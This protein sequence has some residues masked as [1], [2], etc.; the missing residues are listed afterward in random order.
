[1]AATPEV[2]QLAEAVA[3]SLDANPQTRRSAEQT[4]DE[5]QAS[6]TFAVSMLQL[7]ALDSFP[8][9]IRQAA[10]VYLKN[11]ST[12]FY[13]QADWEARSGEPQT[14]LKAGIVGVVLRSPVSV[15]RQLSA[16]LAV[17]AEHEYPT[18]WPALVSELAA[19]LEA[20]ARAAAGAAADPAAA[21]EWG[22]LQ[23]ALES[24]A[25]I[26]ERYPD[27][28]RSDELFTEINVSLQHTAPRLR[29]LLPVM[30]R[31]VTQ[32][33]AARD[34]TAVE[35]IVGNAALMARVF[36]LL[37]WQDL[38]AYIEDNM[39]ALMQPLKQLLEFEDA[40]IDAAADDE[41]SCIDAMHAA[42]IDALNLYAGKYDEEFRPYLQFFVKDVWELLVKRSNVP[43]Y[44]KVV[45]TGIKFLTTV[46]RSPDHTLF[47]DPSAL[48]QVC[49]SI[50]VPNIQL[51][52]ED[53]ELFEDNAVEYIR[54][55]MEGSDSGTRRR[56]AVELVKGLCQNYDKEVTEIFS[57]HVSSML[58]PGSAWEKRDAALYIV[59]ALGWKS[60]TAAHGATETSQ[61]INVVD[62]FQNQV[63]PELTA[64]ASSPTELKAPIFTADLIK[65]AISF[66]VQIPKAS[67][68][69]LIEHCVR[70]LSAKEPVVKT[71]AAACIERLLTVKEPNV[72]T[73]R[74][75]KEDLAPMLSV[76]L[77]HIMDTLQKSTRADE[78]LMR[79]VLRLCSV[80]KEGMKDYAPQLVTS[81]VQV[82]EVVLKNPENPLFNHYLFEAIAALIRFNVTSANVAA[83]E[84]QLNPPLQTILREDVTEFA[85]YVFQVLSQLMSAHAGPLPPTYA[86]LIEPILT[87]NMWEKRGYV[88]SMVQ[89]IEAYC[90]KNSEGVIASGKM[91]GIL[92][93]F[94]KLLAS[95]PLDHLGL[96]LLCTIIETYD[97][98]A[99]AQYIN[100]IV[101]VLMTR[102]MQARTTKYVQNLL[103]T[104]SVFVIRYGVTAL[105]TSLDGQQQG[106]LDTL[107]RQV[108]LPCV[109][110]ILRPGERRVCAVALADIACATDLC[111][112]APYHALW[113][114]LVTAAVKLMEGVTEDAK[115]DEDTGKEEEE[116]A[117]LGGGESYS[118]A[119]SQLQW[120]IS[121]R[122]RAADVAPGVDPK[123]RLAGGIVQLSMRHPGRFGGI[124]ETGVDPAV[125]GAIQSYITATG[126]TVH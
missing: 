14:Q 17:M 93:V 56:G 99:I 112:E 104:L 82:L 111:A 62:F 100:S 95:K 84:A 109:S 115:E 64:S 40:S 123:Q 120:G 61:L 122:R 83:F 49:N 48:A 59:T 110:T 86:Q 94:Q 63:L 44:D 37:S 125:K 32:G 34:P 65:Y 55:D 12:R 102:L 31:V 27:R 114:Q 22:A 78:Y 26:F 60:G 21:I 105:K 80:A 88:P 25:A 91:V 118:A 41:P 108:W 46:A 97:A 47:K 92:G 19:Q 75:S 53:K 67:Y 45:T 72:R 18:R 117:H 4:L 79:L 58:A 71:Y 3:H 89:F 35:L 119:H 52:E 11:F 7:I 8:V 16:V 66:R 24:L 51:R 121:N 36:Y 77:P 81:L 126:L 73:P 5:R 33:L 30:T 69:T 76:L 70:L 20:A 6:P 101:S 39:E 28:M 15:R 74:I 43:K 113:P 9:P 87:P 13:A 29:E 107:L 90:R 50:V 98:N 1:M 2:N 57:G 54:L 38:P 124:L 103:Y 85:P 10:A 23:A 68:V 116:A 96:R 42:I 106:L